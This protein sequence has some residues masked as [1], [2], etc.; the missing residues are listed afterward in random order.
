MSGVVFRTAIGLSVAGFIG[1]TALGA[2]SSAPASVAERAAVAPAPVR[3]AAMRAPVLDEVRPGMWSVQDDGP[4]GAIHRLCLDDAAKLVQ[5]RHS[6]A[7][8]SRM[9]IASGAHEVTIHYSCPGNG[10]GRTSLRID[11]PTSVRIDTQGIADNAPFAYQAV[12]R[13]EGDCSTGLR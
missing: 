12:A 5:V 9:L 4:G 10:W 3:M 2:G 6:D 8:C 11:S 13:R 1:L 7:A